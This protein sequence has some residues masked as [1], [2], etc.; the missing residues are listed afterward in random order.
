MIGKLA[1]PTRLS[2]LPPWQI[3]LAVVGGSIVLS[4]LATQLSL[5]LSDADTQTLWVASAIAVLAPAIAAS[6]C[7]WVLL[8]MLR[9]LRKSSEHAERLAN[10]DSLTGALNRRRF[11]ELALASIKLNTAAG[12]PSSLILLDVDDFKVVNDTHGHAAG[13]MV[14]QVLATSIRSWI[15]SEDVIARWGGEEFV[16]LLSGME[17]EQA[18][19]IAERIRLSISM[20]TI[21]ANACEQKITISA[22]L[23]TQY[24]RSHANLDLLISNADAAMYSAKTQGKNRVM[25]WSSPEHASERLSGQAQASLPA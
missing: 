14:L 4:Q 12:R 23:V 19:T 20:E 15:G 6:C 17:S 2:S 21:V 11:T 7:T 13:D 22:G 18:L 5:Y 1:W 9:E 10:I 3:Y 25:V 24:P 16:V 8:Q